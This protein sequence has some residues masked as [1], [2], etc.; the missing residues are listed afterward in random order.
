[1]AAYGNFL[2]A[3][4]TEDTFVGSH[5]SYTLG[6]Q[7]PLKQWVDLYNHCWTLR[8]LTIEI[9]EKLLF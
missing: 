5:G 8:V 6:F 1:M 4:K 9:G 2:I 3:P 7:P